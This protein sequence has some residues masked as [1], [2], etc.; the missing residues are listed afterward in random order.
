MPRACPCD[1]SFDAVINVEAAHG[2][3]DFPRFLAEVAPV[4]RPGGRFLYADM[5]VRR[6]R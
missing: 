6:A 3:P 4:L 1:E 2:Y 5:S